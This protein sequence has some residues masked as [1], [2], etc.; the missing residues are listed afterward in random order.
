MISNQLLYADCWLLLPKLLLPSPSLPPPHH[1]TIYCHSVSQLTTIT[2]SLWPPS[3]QWSMVQSELDRFKPLACD[4]GNMQYLVAATLLSTGNRPQLSD[5]ETRDLS[6]ERVDRT[7][8]NF[9]RAVV[10][11]WI[12]ILRM[13]M[14][15]FSF[16]FVLDSLIWYWN[17]VLLACAGWSSGEGWR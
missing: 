13:Q 3:S 7:C 2:L 9:G 6:V 17:L 16:V 11:I 12:L 4:C 15:R 14:E 8:A 1:I 10:W 5:Y